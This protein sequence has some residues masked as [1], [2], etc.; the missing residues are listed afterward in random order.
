[1]AGI[2]MPHFMTP[3][4]IRLLKWILIPVLSI[5]LLI[6]ITGR[7][8]TYYTA[9]KVQKSLASLGSKVG[10]LDVNLFLQRITLND[11]ELSL[12]G[13]SSHR[14]PTTARIQ[15]IQFKSISLYQLLIKKRIKIKEILIENGTINFNKTVTLKDTTDASEISVTGVT[16]ENFVVRKIKVSIVNDSLHEFSGMLN[17]TLNNLHSSEGA[18]LMDFKKY[19]LKNI[20]AK[21]SRLLIT[22]PKLYQIEIKNIHA[23]SEDKKLQFDSILLRP[24]YSKYKFARIAGKQTDRIN[25]FIQKVAVQ[26]LRYNQLKDSLFLASH[27]QIVSGEVYSF[28]DK[29]F[30]FRETKNK[31]LPMAALRDLNFAIEVDSIRI[32]DSKI[33]YEEFP[34]EGFKSGKVVFEKLNATLANLSSHAYYNKPDYATLKASAMLMGRGFIQTTFLLPQQKDKPYRAE[35]KIGGLSLHHLNPILQN[36]AFISIESGRLNELNF[37]FEYTDTFSNGNVIINYQDLKINGLKKER[38]A[39]ISDL[40][41]FLINTVVKNDKDKSVATEKRTG[42]IT[43]E[44]DKKR[45]IFNYWWK[46][47]F[48]GIKSSVLDK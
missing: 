10:E 22:T 9:Q 5:L 3:L 23:N 38:S 2:K 11:F 21:I 18:D 46:S 47:L 8:L 27:I 17:A 43:F 16:V 41:T 12:T 13:D 6:F 36:L 37:N 40:K 39:V 48:S 34:P 26:G 45:Q 14:I 44:R 4:T 7:I 19:G 24:K 29:R 1:M 33:T 35:G 42:R 30:P 32:K 31:P 15:T 25:V 28:R 20:D